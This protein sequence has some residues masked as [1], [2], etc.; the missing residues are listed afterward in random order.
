MITFLI[1]IIVGF[2]VPVVLNNVKPSSAKSIEPRL[3]T[4]DA[5]CSLTCDEQSLPVFC[6]NNLC[7]QNSCDES[8]LFPF[9]PI[10]VEFTL[11][12]ILDNR[13]IDFS[14]RTSSDNFY[15]TFNKNTV[16]L[17][18]S[19][20]SLNNVLEK[21]GMAI[22]N[23]CLF[24]DS[25]SY[26]TTTQKNLTMIINRNSTFPYGE[27]IPQPQDNILIQYS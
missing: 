19:S 10:P 26:C 8:P 21:V 1:L 25:T 22:K 13:T 4:N 3:C 15:V 5:Q 7:Q 16:Y 6:S 27:Y 17:S 18:A 9:Q 20:L 12:I 24:M 14:N 23:Q 11:M 2:T